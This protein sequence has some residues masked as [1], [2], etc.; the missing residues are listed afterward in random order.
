MAHPIKRDAYT[1]TIDRRG[2]NAGP[3][4]SV[5]AKKTR[6]VRKL[7]LR[8]YSWKDLLFDASVIGVVERNY[9]ILSREN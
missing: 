2:K 4:L 8:L 9:E 7:M 3:L 6:L 1:R 5:R